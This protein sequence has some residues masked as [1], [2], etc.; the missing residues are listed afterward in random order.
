MLEYGSKV[1]LNSNFK[2]YHEMVMSLYAQLHSLQI[3]MQNWKA[4]DTK[5]ESLLHEYIDFQNEL[6]SLIKMK[7]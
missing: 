6:K 3:I 1:E 2:I 4:I 5:K 7:Q